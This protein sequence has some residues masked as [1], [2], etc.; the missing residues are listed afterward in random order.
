MSEVVSLVSFELPGSIGNDLPT[1]HQNT[2]QSR[3][4]CITIDLKLTAI[5]WKSKDESMSKTLF[6]LLK[7]QFATLILVEFDPLSGQFSE[8]QGNH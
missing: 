8:K 3:Q 7:T 4:G 5:V 6:K 2:T 1:L